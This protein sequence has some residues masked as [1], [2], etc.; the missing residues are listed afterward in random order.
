[1]SLKSYFVRSYSTGFVNVAGSAIS[2]ALLIPIIIS[3]VGLDQWGIW[4]M[5]SI[6]LGLGTAAELGVGKSL[7]YYLPKAKSE[8]ERSRIYS[9]SILINRVGLLAMLFLVTGLYLTNLGNP[10]ELKAIPPYL[11]DVILVAGISLLSLLVLTSPYRGALEGSLKIDLVNIGF[12]IQSTLIYVVLFVVVS[13][14]GMALSMIVSTVLVFVLVFVFHSLMVS[15]KTSLGWR[16]PAFQNVREVLRFS[17]GIYLVGLINSL[18]IPINRGLVVFFSEDII[19][20]AEFDISLRFGLMALSAL[21]VFT[22]PLLGVLSDKDGLGPIKSRKLI[23]RSSLLVLSLAIAGNVVFYLFGSKLLGFFLDQN[24]TIEIYRMTMT[25]L[26][27]LSIFGIAEPFKRAL[28][29]WGALRDLLVINILFI[30][31]NLAIF[32]VISVDSMELRVAISYSVS[33]ALIGIIS[34]AWT[35]YKMQIFIPL[36]SHEKS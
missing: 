26:V 2:V 21:A 20:Y 13:L 32:A 28:F 31:A 33:A 1:M 25:I 12:F 11:S 9:S 5:L 8:C 17:S 10:F 27:G 22:S 36:S 16:R 35:I 23:Y 15:R 24:N 6:F 4:A 3:I 30:G 14:G 18:I 7:V 19:N 34:I 29:A